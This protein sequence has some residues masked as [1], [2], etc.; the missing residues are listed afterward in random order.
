[1]STV[2]FA[3]SGEY[4][5]TFINQSDRDLVIKVAE[6]KNINHPHD[7]N[8]K[9]PAGE[10]RA[11]TLKVKHRKLS[12]IAPIYFYEPSITF[13][14]NTNSE[15][16]EKV[17]KIKEVLRRLFINTF[18]KIQVQ[19]QQKKWMVEHELDNNDHDVTYTFYVAK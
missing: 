2:S 5:H 15:S 4:K 12:K 17:F 10:R 11:V 9:I 3:D 1:M 13:R 6:H 7:L 18:F 8:L 16:G 14:I 19:F